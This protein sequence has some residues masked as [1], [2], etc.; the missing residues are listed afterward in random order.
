[1]GGNIA[2]WYLYLGGDNYRYGSIKLTN[3]T[4]AD[5]NVPLFGG[6]IFTY[7]DLTIDSSSI[8]SNVSGHHG[9][10]IYMAAS[11]H[12][13]V[14]I[15]NSTISGNNADDHGGG[16]YKESGPLSIYA[17]TIAS[18]TSQQEGGNIYM[19]VEQGANTNVFGSLIAYGDCVQNAVVSQGYNLESGETCGFDQATDQRNTD[20]LLEPLA[21]NG[22]PTLTHLPGLDSPAIDAFHQ[23]RLSCPGPAW[24][25]ASDRRSL[26]HRR[27]GSR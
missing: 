18:N 26:R 6:G 4:V 16:I 20:P 5:G 8:L 14:S 19:D 1:M 3:T 11:D 27:G 24:R 17:S 7:G 13:S 9:G 2:N 21:D 12:G 15:Q 25:R 23:L 10:G 22:G